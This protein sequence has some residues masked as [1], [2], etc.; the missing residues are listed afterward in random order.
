MDC[1]SVSALSHG[2]AVGETSL[3]PL[4]PSAVQCP[5]RA[6]PAGMRIIRSSSRCR[7]VSS[8]WLGASTGTYF[9][10]PGARTQAYFECYVVAQLV[11]ML[12]GVFRDNPHSH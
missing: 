11:H 1:K 5:V 9:G 12:R 4:A 10:T 7:F 2:F 3:W 6:G 8:K